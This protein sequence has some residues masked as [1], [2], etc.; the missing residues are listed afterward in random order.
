LC[1]NINFNLTRLTA[2]DIGEFTG[3]YDRC[4]WLSLAVPTCIGGGYS[5]WFF[6]LG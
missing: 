4:E 2:S 5:A 3:I 6:S 1:D